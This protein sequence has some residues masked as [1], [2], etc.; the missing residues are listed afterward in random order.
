MADFMAIDWDQHELCGLDAAVTSDRVR[1]RQSFGL[2][3]PADLDRAGP[4]AGEWLRQELAQRGVRARQTVVSLP[5]DAF[6]VR[7]LG[8]PNVPDDQL[9]SVVQLQAE[10]KTSSPMERLVL[11]FLPLPHMSPDGSRQVLMVTMARERFEQIR[12]TVVAAG[13]ELI[14]IGIRPVAIAELVARAEHRMGADSSATT[15]MVVRAG[16]R[17]EVSLMR[18]HCLL[19]MHSAQL[20][21]NDREPDDRFALSEIRRAMGAA[22]RFDGNIDVERAWIVDK[23]GEH[24]DLPQFVQDQCQC[25][26]ATVDP[27]ADGSVSLESSDGT[28]DR[29]LSGSSLAGPVGMLLAAGQPAVESVDFLHPRRP[30]VRVDRRR[31]GVALA[32]VVVLLSVVAAWAVTRWR[33]NTLEIQIASKQDELTRLSDAAKKGQATL[34]AAALVESWERRNVDWLQHLVFLNQVLPGTD[35]VYL[36]DFRMSPVAADHAAQLQATGFAK[37]RHDVQ[38]LNRHLAEKDYLVRPQEISRNDKDDQYPFQFQL[39]IAIP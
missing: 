16:R 10:T 25:D 33:V 4:T 15:L 23:P 24:D 37:T 1:V 6:V 3:W 28:F 27:L 12:D 8:V 14:S 18:S 39:D 22:S 32:V 34:D 36:T 29:A 30:V 17:L 2:E 20:S 26:V 38:Q 11:D 9:A 7:Q 21:G 5:R 19:F 13:L 35:R 31:H